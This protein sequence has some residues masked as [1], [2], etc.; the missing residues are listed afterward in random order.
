MPNH[1]YSQLLVEGSSSLIQSLLAYCKDSE[2]EL[3]TDQIYPMPPELKA[4]SSSPPKIVSEEEYA[5][6]KADPQA[7]AEGPITKRMKREYEQKFGASDWYAWANKFW[8]TKWGFYN[9]G[10]WAINSNDSAVI[11]FQTAW[12]PA[13]PVVTKLSAEFPAIKITYSFADEG[14]DFVG[15]QIFESGKLVKQNTF[16]W[17]SQDGIFIRKLV[18][19]YRE[20]DDEDC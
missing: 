1:I 19:E 20:E 16:P 9:V 15:N 11:S 3:S 17:D 5:K 7:R 2:T 14:G 12:S 18:G 10:K 13:T 4:V 8:G 6:W